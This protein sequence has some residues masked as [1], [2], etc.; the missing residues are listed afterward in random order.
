MKYKDPV[1]GE[2]KELYTKTADTL[3]VGSIVDFEG[4]EVPEGWEAVEETPKGCVYARATIL[5][6]DFKLSSSS[7]IPLN[8]I[9]SESGTTYFKLENNGIVVNS[10][11]IKKV[12]VSGSMFVDAPTGTGYVWGQLRR[13]NSHFAGSITVY[14]NAGGFLSSTIPPIVLNVAKGD[15]FTLIGD[16]TVQGTVRKDYPN[17]WLIV[18]V[19]EW[20]EV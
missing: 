13:N 14:N 16:S 1:T 20:N 12:E 5:N 4:N 17:T 18:K 11:K 6:T 8:T 19:V 10:D 7:K 15:T 3:P 9:S 2:W